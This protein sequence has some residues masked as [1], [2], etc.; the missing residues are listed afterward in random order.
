MKTI[1]AGKFKA[2]CLALLDSVAQNGEPMI[3][4]KHGKPVAKLVSY[5]SNKDVHEN[6]LKGLATYI[7]DIISPIDE[8][9]EAEKE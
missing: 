4:T 1:Q 2:Q 7:G 6:P 8:E 9:W 3:I 5:D